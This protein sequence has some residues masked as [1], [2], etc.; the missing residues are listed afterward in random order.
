MKNKQCKLEFPDKVWNQFSRHALDFV[1]KLINPDPVS[2]LS[3]FEAL[4]H[5]WIARGKESTEVTPDTALN[6]YE[7]VELWKVPT[8]VK[9]DK[10][11]FRKRE[12]LRMGNLN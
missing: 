12:D 4:N 5:R 2:R 7:G 6:D 3:A 8:L 11:E 1:R 10:P 9:I